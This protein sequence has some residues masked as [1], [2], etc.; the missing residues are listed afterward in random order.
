VKRRAILTGLGAGILA[1][2][3]LA[4]VLPSATA[5]PAATSV[6]GTV[7]ACDANPA[8]GSAT[9]LALALAGPDGR[10][11]RTLS[12]PQDGFTPTD[13]QAAYNLKGLKSGGRT[14]A[15]VDAFGYSTL[16]ADL[17]MYRKTYDLP[18][19]TTKNGC[20]TI[21]DQYGGHNYPPDNAGW[22]LEQALD[23]DAVSATCPDC[24]ILMVQAKTNGGYN[25]GLA[26]N[27]GATQKGVVA[28]SNSWTAAGDRRRH[29]E[30]NHRG[31]AITAATGD[32]GSQGGAYPADD[33]HVVAVAGTSVTRD[34]SQR[35]YSEAA[36]SGSG[37]GCSKVTHQPRWQQPLDTGCKTRAIGDV[38]AAADPGLGGLVI[39]FQGQF[40]TV[41]GTSEASP[42]IASVYALS[43]NTTG[44]P[45]R[46]PYHH[47]QFL[48]DVT[49][50]SNGGCGPPICVAGK[51]W[52]GPTGVG[53]PNGI[54]GF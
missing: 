26:A 7:R 43:G 34:G 50:G 6:T 10:A 24:K 52:D 54:K 40:E 37:S 5:R 44:Y 25:M 8:R 51:G 18:P 47:T 46:L 4:A 17:A 19:C 14:V 21:I 49:N 53:T 3:G 31:I 16:E 45:S 27:R 38:S 30:F 13:I 15:I 1:L 33:P 29:P 41:G 35:G 9:C 20:L 28:E 22:D 48:Y 11:L 36:W 2:S 23:V 12:P 39:C 42:I 32:G